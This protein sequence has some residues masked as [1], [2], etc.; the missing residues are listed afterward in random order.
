LT[1]IFN[2]TDFTERRRALRN[3]MSPP[4]HLLWSRL[5]GKQICGCKFRRQY[6][7]GQYIVDFYC[8]ELRLVIELDGDS[9]SSAE[10]WR[11]D[12]ERQRHIEAL[13]LTVIRFANTEIFSN[14]DQVT[15]QIAITAESMQV[16]RT[17][18]SPQPPPS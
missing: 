18:T 14:L 12:Q 4:E 17:L 6:G 1:Q 15:E 2:K 16:R 3:G 5:R 9:H 10:A 7:I 13:G 8:V 11:R